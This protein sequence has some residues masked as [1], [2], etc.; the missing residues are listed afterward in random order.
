M[1]RILVTGSDGYIGAV[2]MQLLQEQG[3]TVTGLDTLYFD[4]AVLG[5]YVRQYALLKRDIR[6]LD[7]LD[8]SRFDA[9]VHLAALSNDATGQMNASLTEEINYRATVALAQKAKQGGVK[10]FLFSSSCSMY[11][12][13]D[14]TPAQESSPIRPLTAYAKSK[15]MA[16]EALR[17]L[18]GKR[19]CVAVLRNATVYGFSPKFRNDLVVNNLVTSALALQ[20]IEIHSDGTPW[21][22]LMDVRD[23]AR[24]FI[25]FLI[26]DAGDISGLRINVGFDENNFQIKHIVDE[27]RSAMP[28]CR[29]V[30]THRHGA[31][32]RSYRVSF[33]KF[34][35]LF[36]H[37][38]QRWPVQR[39]VRDLI[40]NLLRYHY[41]KQDFVNRRFDRMHA[42]KQ[43]IGHKKLNKEL[44]WI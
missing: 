7:S 5:I 18:A 25:A 44:F 28:S 39:S 15:A 11:G 10:R 32:T 26:A 30:Y 34:K 4:D 41:A 12:I 20:R 8:L 3:Y 35:T 2:L 29:V 37:I 43:L 40:R 17:S 21:R 14:D 33:K 31:D 24:A 38:T 23:L 36:P 22:P 1:K 19:F 13:R 16:E 27:V 42:L 9:I 6:S